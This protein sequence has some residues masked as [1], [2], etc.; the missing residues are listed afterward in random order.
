[1]AIRPFCVEWD[2]FFFKRATPF[3][4]EKRRGPLKRV[5]KGSLLG[6][7]W[8]DP[9]VRFSRL[10]EGALLRALAIYTRGRCVDRTSAGPLRLLK[11][12]CCDRRSQL[13]LYLG[14]H[15]DRPTD[16]PTVDKSAEAFGLE[17]CRSEGRPQTPPNPPDPG[18]GFT[19]PPPSPTGARQAGHFFF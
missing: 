9:G 10:P 8:D 3:G 6:P 13:T 2:F 17:A 14:W 18:E 19:P 1:M 12:P 16:R 4:T 11:T 7:F 5:P 15:S